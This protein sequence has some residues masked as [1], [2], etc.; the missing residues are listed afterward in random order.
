MVA[1]GKRTKYVKIQNIQSKNAK[2]VIFQQFLG[3]KLNFRFA[4]IQRK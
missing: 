1:K 4:E 3:Q 2:N